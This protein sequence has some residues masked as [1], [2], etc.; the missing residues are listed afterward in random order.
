MQEPAVTVGEVDLDQGTGRTRVPDRRPQAAADVLA[1]D[2]ELV[3]TR[4]ALGVN[5]AVSRC[6]VIDDDRSEPGLA[7]FQP[8]VE[9][10]D[11]ADEVR[12]KRRRR[13]V[14]DLLRRSVLLDHAV[15]E[16]DDAIGQLERFLL[17]VGDEHTRQP[18]LVVQAPQPATQFLADLG[19]ERPERL[20]EEEHCRLNREG[21]RERH[22]LPLAARELRRQPVSEEVEL[23][24]RQQLVDARANLVFSGPRLPRP[25][26]HAERDVL[27]DGHVAE[28]RVVLEHEADVPA[29]GARGRGVLAVDEHRALVG[30]IEAGDD[31]QQRRL[32]RSR[33][34]EERKELARWHHQIDAAQSLKRAERPRGIAY[35]DAHVPDPVAPIDAGTAASRTRRLRF[36]TIVCSTSVRTAT[37]AS[38]DATAN[39]A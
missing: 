25:H 32:A 8:A 2:V 28:E 23:H 12:D 34:T 3:R 27:E 29:T 5:G 30:P 16:N 22:A 6:G 19:V 26:P 31:P 15:V 39:D 10:V 35:F 4:V 13:M 33:W 9:H 24:Q 38:S 14:D 21:A 18:N 20:V 37:I 7:G 1:R 36:S 17:I 11:P